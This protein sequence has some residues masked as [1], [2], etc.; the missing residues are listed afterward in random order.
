MLKYINPKAV[1]PEPV[2]IFAK[3]SEL[4]HARAP[5]RCSKPGVIANSEISL[6][7]HITT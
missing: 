2:V 3:P 6:G 4:P 1:A 5:R 7:K